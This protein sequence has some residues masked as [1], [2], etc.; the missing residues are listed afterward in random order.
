MVSLLLT[1]DFGLLLLQGYRTHFR[2]QLIIA[3]V[4]CICISIYIGKFGK[5]YR[6][7]LRKG[8]SVI[9]IAV[10]TTKSLL[11]I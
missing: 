10:K 8:D 11:S 3:C 4:N 2:V 5:V 9:E 7:Q 1:H 6:G